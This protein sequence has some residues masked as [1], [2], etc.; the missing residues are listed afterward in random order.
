MSIASSKPSAPNILD[1]SIL[2]VGGEQ[3]D[4][5][6]HWAAVLARRGHRIVR[7][8]D[9]DEAIARF[10]A[11]AGICVVI[12][13][14]DH[15]ANDGIA[16]IEA[17][18]AREAGRAAEYIVVAGGNA[19]AGAVRA[20]RL[21][22]LDFLV[23]PVSDEDL[24][25]AVSDACNVARMK[26]FQY[27]E[28]RALEALLS[29]FKMRTHAAVS[30]LISRAQG[31]YNI[32]PRAV[33]YPTTAAP[34]EDGALQAFVEE[35]SE[36]ARLREKVFGALVQNHSVWILLLA[37]WDSQRAGTELTVKSVAYAAGLPLSSALRKIN[38][39]SE[40]GLI[41]KRGDPDDARRSFVSLTAQG[42]SYFARFFQEWDAS[43]LG[44][45][46]AASA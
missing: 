10:N 30:Q 9:G 44:R 4:D 3:N 14:L 7:A 17:L 21:Q 37:L 24:A 1:S 45:K 26:Q 31:A 16:L 27:E 20:I 43:R 18:R 33:P 42:R 2:L 11:D 22:V 41:T 34:S 46:P 13:D 36:R 39:M 40:N 6:A 15:D 12:A 32:A 23:K 19:L 8:R 25:T 35:E 5:C 29:E 28:A 38:E